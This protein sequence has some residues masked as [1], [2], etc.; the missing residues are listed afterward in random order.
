M[1]KTVQ[2][3][4]SY[5]DL[6][7]TAETVNSSPTAVVT[8]VN[9][10]PTGNVSITGTATQNQ[11]LTATNT[12]ADADGLGTLNYQWQESDDN[13]V[14]WTDISGATNDTFALSQTQVG[15]NI[16]VK[17][18]Y[19]DELGTQETVNSSPTS[20]VYAL[21]NN[22]PTGN[23][24]ITGT[25]KQ[26]QI[27]TATNTL[28]D[29]DGLGMFNYQ[30]QESSDNGVTWTDISEATNNTF[31]LSQAQVGKNIQV[32]VSYTDG[33]G[34]QETVN[35]SPTS[36]VTNVNDLPTGTVNITG[37]AT[38]NQ[39]LT[40]TNTLAD[41]DGLGTLNYQWQES[42]DNG[43]ILPLQLPSQLLVTI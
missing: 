18:S 40:A 42:A 15:K 10:L 26:N 37:T 25:P 27:L 33:Q 7:G 2:V 1:G 43:V 6:L 21:L 39:I 8:N 30:W 5:T 41:V 19:T 38:Q 32:K 35:S 3:K 31:T 11:I 16:Q 9:D 4:V 24:S 29:F 36:V 12:L 14:T 13:G 20:L 28:A 23:V 34:T 17:V 22:V